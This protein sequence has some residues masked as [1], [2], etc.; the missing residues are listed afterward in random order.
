MLS[1]DGDHF[2]GVVNLA[3]RM[4]KLAAPGAV[5]TSTGIRDA[6]DAYRFAPAG[7]CEL[8]GFDA[9]DRRLRGPSTLTAER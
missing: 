4:I 7:T 8:K 5:L 9:A 3:S 2:G 6:V 1:R